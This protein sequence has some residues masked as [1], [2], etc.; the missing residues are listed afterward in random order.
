MSR[1]RSAVI[2]CYRKNCPLTPFEDILADAV[3]FGECHDGYTGVLGFPFPKIAILFLHKTVEE[4]MVSV[5]K[6]K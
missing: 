2:V 6:T 1:Y 3:T 4:K 5:G